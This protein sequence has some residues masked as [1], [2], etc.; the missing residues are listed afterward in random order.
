MRS[1]GATAIGNRVPRVP[2]A[3]IAVANAIRMT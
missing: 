3:A 2:A 1:A